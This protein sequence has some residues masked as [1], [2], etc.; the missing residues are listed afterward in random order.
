MYTLMDFQ[1]H[2]H[3]EFAEERKHPPPSLLECPNV[4]ESS[5]HCVR[6]AMPQL[7]EKAT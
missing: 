3:G 1:Y 7:L 2:K 4:A 6:E 5:L